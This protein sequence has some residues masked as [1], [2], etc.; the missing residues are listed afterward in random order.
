MGALIICQT[1]AQFFRKCPE[2]CPYVLDT[3]CGR[4]G[5]SCE[6]FPNICSFNFRKCNPDEWES[7]LFFLRKVFRSFPIGELFSDWTLVSERACPKECPPLIN[8]EKPISC[9]EA[10]YPVC[11]QDAEGCLRQFKNFCELQ[12]AQCTEEGEPCC[13]QCLNAIQ[14][15]FSFIQVW[16]L[17]GKG[18]ALSW[19]AS[20]RL[21]LTIAKVNWFNKSF[22][23]CWVFFGASPFSS[24][25][26]LF[27]L[28][29]IPV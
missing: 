23:K 6:P 25:G 28:D 18:L 14:H 21:Q 16:I 17:F 27:L 10:G 8:C 19:R 29:F 26:F 20:Q 12:K 4:N 9:N 24:K 15:Q 1:E 11:A 5:T 13:K 7:E 3:V 2:Y 22:Q